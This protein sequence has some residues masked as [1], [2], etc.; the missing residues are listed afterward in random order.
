MCDAWIFRYVEKKI[1][2]TVWWGKSAGA[3]PFMW[4][5]APIKQ[6]HCYIYKILIINRVQYC[7]VPTFVYNEEMLHEISKLYL[8]LLLFSRKMVRTY[9]RK[10]E[11][12]NAGI[13]YR[14]SYTED[15]IQCSECA[16]WWHEAC[17][18]YETGCFV[19]DNCII[20]G[21]TRTCPIVNELTPTLKRTCPSTGARSFI[22]TAFYKFLYPI[23][24]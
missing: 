21:K 1:R 17:T 18:A 8:C 11:R 20:K 6:Y 5:L 23:N 13:V 14:S 12:R 16:T 22:C 4:G 15:C 3:S 10:T 2:L 19:C 24:N 9:V 7:N